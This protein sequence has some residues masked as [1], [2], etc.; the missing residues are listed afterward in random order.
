MPLPLRED[1]EGVASTVATLFILVIVMLLL[2]SSVIGTIPAKQYEA[3]RLTSLE[4]ISAFDQLRSMSSVLATPYDQFTVALPLGTPAVSPFATPTNGQL[5]FNP[6]EAHANASYKFVPRLFDARISKID[7]DVI[8]AIDASGSM[9]CCP[10]PGNDPS[11]LRI[12][13][14]KDYVSHL[15][16]PDRVAVVGFDSA[17]H[18]TKIGCGTP[19]NAYTAH[20][21]FTP[22]HYGPN[23]S[24]V[25]SDLDCIGSADGTNYGA[26]LQVANDELI[27]NGDPKHA[28]AVILLTDGYNTCCPDQAAGDA[29]ALSEARRAAARGIVVFTIGLGSGVDTN[30][31]TQIASITGGTYY[32]APDATAIRYI[33]FEIA[34]HFKGSITCGTLTASNPMG[35][36]LSLTLANRQYPSQTVRIESSGVSVAQPNGGVVHEGI[37]VV[38]E[39]SGLGT[40][41]LRLTQLSFVG[42]SYSASGT[43]YQFLS[44]QFLGATVEDTIITRPNLAVES[45]EVTNVSLFVKYWGDKGFATPGAVSGIQG[46]LGQ[47]SA[48][49]TWGDANMTARDPTKAKF[50]VDSAQSSLSAAALRVSQEVTAGNMDPALG[51]A[52]N[53]DIIRIGC[54]LDQFKNWWEG[55]TFSIQTPNAA[56]WAVWFNDTFGFAG[57]PLSY[58]TAGDQVILT[59]RAVDRFV[60]TERTISVGFN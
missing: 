2:Q 47:A 14:A 33:Y 24:E 7:Q 60:L 53:N 57:V 31:L 50:N 17:A 21:L 16:Y 32:A 15:T 10:S 9:T 48:K 58:G 45:M 55:V 20:H 12:A 13:G 27:T 51:N 28:W 26:A 11:R 35:G 38:V 40:A 42:P 6:S 23:Y 37:P 56:A 46:I 43:D 41:T 52:T 8:L 3:E 59:I 22:G 19:P 49:L 5:V 1:S 39:P 34:M 18:L 36:S 29:Q 25:W 44:G 54:A 30:M 4:A